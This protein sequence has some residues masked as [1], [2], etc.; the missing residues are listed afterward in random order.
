MDAIITTRRAGVAEMTTLAAVKVGEMETAEAAELFRKC[1]KL[2]SP[3]PDMNTEVLQ[4]VSELGKLAPAIML[5]GCYIA[6]IP[7]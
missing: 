3:G 1:A 4:I 7:G 5:A 2:R 6:A